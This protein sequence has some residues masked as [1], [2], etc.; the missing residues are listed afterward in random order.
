MIP[1]DIA[2]NLFLNRVLPECIIPK[3]L[4]SDSVVV[5]TD[6]TTSTHVA[7]KPRENIEAASYLISTPSGYPFDHERSKRVGSPNTQISIIEAGTIA[8]VSNR[9]EISHFLSLG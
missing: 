1:E 2:S 6:Q 8:V 4:E 7:P 3:I 9:T 5:V